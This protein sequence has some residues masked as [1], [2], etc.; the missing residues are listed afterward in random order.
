MAEPVEMVVPPVSALTG[1]AVA[2]A[3]ASILTALTAV[4][5]ETPEPKVPAVRVDQ[6]AARPS[7]DEPALPASR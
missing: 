2:L 4:P 7:P 6:P 5:G 1:A 3:I